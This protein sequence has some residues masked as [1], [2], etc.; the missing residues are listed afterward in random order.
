MADRER[1]GRLLA[2]Q[3]RRRRHR[4]LYRRDAASA[5]RDAASR[6]ASR[7]PATATRANLALADFVA[8]KETGLADYVG[9]FAVTA[10]IG[11]EDVARALRARQR[12]LLHDH[13]QG[14]RRPA[15]GSLRRGAARERAQRVL[16]LCAGR[17]AHQRGAD[18]AKSTAASAR[19]R[20]IRPSPTTPRSA[21]LFDLLD[22]EKATG[23]QLTES[24]AMWPG[25]CRLGPLLLASRQPLFRRR[26]DR[27]ATR[28]R[29]TRARKGW[30][31]DEAERWLAPILNY[32][33]KR[34]ADAAE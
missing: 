15:G 29:T 20:A 19:R 18:R 1:R 5:A 24:F 32:D 4:A 33:P 7:W 25:C 27:A 34:I 2:G 6:C 22:A 13:G 26:Q 12:R 8:P 16:G 3:Q 17:D 10:G 28:S 14:A 23:M 9:G 31:L 21:T 30:E 11:E